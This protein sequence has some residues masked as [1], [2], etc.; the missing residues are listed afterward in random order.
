MEDFQNIT[1]FVVSYVQSWL[2]YQTKAL[3]QLCVDVSKPETVPKL[4]FDWLLLQENAK[5]GS[6]TANR[7]ASYESRSHALYFQS[8]A[9]SFSRRHNVLQLTHSVSVYRCL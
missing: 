9:E 5:R 8:M 4:N 7:S 6:P 2:K 3:I 1:T